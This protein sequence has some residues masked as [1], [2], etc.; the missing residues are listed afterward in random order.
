MIDKPF[1]SA[2][3]RNSEAILGV[4]RVELA[5]CDSVL[6]IGAGTGQHAAYFAAELPNLEWQASDLPEN[7]DGIRSWRADADLPNLREPIALDVRWDSAPQDGHGAVFSAN[8]VHIM[9]WEVVQRMFGLVANVLVERGVFVLYGPLRSAGRFNAQSNAEFD[10]SLRRRDPE[11]GIR[12]LEKLD[13]LASALRLQ[14][15]RI[16]AMPANNYISVWIKHGVG[17]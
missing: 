4:L 9:S 1:A 12:D 6:E 10:R 7:L 16:Y 8:T 15:A 14:R 17:R 13:E 5:D 3:A 11:M 2:A